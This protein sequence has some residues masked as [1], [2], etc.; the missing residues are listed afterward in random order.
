M[1]LLLNAGEE[2]ARGNHVTDSAIAGALQKNE[3]SGPM[4]PTNADQRSIREHGKVCRRLALPS[5]HVLVCGSRHSG[6]WGA[7]DQEI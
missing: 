4:N 7:A 1:F 3:G 5:V 2:K 6:R